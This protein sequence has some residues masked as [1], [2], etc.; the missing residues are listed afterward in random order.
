M[1]GAEYKVNDP[2]LKQSFSPWS[3]VM[4]Y[5][6]R[7]LSHRRNVPS[8]QIRVLN[9]GSGSAESSN[10]CTVLSLET[11]ADRLPRQARKAPMMKRCY[12]RK[13]VS[14][15]SSRPLLGFLQI[16]YTLLRHEAPISS[17]ASSI[18]DFQIK[19][20]DLRDS[21]RAFTD[22]TLFGNSYRTGSP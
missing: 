2:R 3:T 1:M 15:Q 4:K 14:P 17:H 6:M 12:S 21:S 13:V 20:L 9:H 5:G 22:Q 7:M 18:S 10:E 16:C 8:H 11:G 19:D